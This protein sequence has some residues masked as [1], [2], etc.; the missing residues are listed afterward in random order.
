MDEFEQLVEAQKLRF[1]DLLKYQC[2][3]ASSFQCTETKP[4]DWIDT[5]EI[6]AKLIIEL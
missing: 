2:E 4:D 5:P 3:S 6:S 1:K